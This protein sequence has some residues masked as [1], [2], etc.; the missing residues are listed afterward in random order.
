MSNK[1]LQSLQKIK[2]EIMEIEMPKLDRACL[3][4]K[5]WPN[6]HLLSHKGRL[7]RQLKD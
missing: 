7:E 2:G 6:D 4:G 1:S 3:P 5:E